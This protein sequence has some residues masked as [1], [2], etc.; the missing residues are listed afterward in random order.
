V[1]AAG[2]RGKVRVLLAAME[3]HSDSS[4]SNGD[5]TVACSINTTVTASS[6]VNEGSD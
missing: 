1:R 5:S 4:C 2:N 6:E 3:R